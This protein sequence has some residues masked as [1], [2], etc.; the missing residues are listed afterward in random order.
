MTNDILFNGVISCGKHQG[1][2]TEP[3]LC[4]GLAGTDEVKGRGL[5]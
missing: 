3:V 2:D 1:R 4:T 5:F